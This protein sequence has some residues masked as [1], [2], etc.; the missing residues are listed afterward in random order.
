MYRRFGKRL[1]D[2]VGG[3]CLG[4]ILWPFML[5]TCVVVRWKLGSPVLFQQQ[6]AGKNGRIF[7]VQ[8][9]RSMTD[10]RDAEHNLLPDEQR[11]T[12]TGKILRASSL[13]ELPQLWNVI[14]GDMSLVGPRP[15]LTEYLPR[16]NPHQAR[17]HEVRPGITG[18][19][20]VNG[21]N[22]VSWEDRFNLDVYYVDNLSLGLDLKILFLTLVKVFRRGEVSS[23]THAT[24]EKFMGSDTG[25]NTHSLNP[26]SE[27]ASNG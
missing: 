15:L 2:L 6:R 22:Q 9:F 21:R 8:K 11:L 26:Q 23:S 3:C 7:E 14:R 24:M 12:T 18:W 20:Q 16:Y 4:L 13:D 1:F 25:Q 5:V 17:R 10:Q 19:A 27:P